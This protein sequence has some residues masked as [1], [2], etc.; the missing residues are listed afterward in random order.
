MGGFILTMESEL[1]YHFVL[2]SAC[3]VWDTCA[4]TLGLEWGTFIYLFI[5]LLIYFSPHL[6]V[7][8]NL[9]HYE[10]MDF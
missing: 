4:I 10:F 5:Y 1:A 8:D 9:Q 7:S 2:C 6:S 3:P